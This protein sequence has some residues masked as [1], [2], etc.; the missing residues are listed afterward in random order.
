[1][2][3]C[4]L[5]SNTKSSSTQFATSPEA[6]QVIKDLLDALT[7]PSEEDSIASAVDTTALATDKVSPSARRHL[8]L[9]RSSSTNEMNVQYPDDQSPMESE[10]GKLPETDTVTVVSPKNLT[11]KGRRPLLTRWNICKLLAEFVR[12]YS[13]VAKLVTEHIYTP[14][15]TE[16]V[17]NECSA[18]SYMLDC[19]VCGS[20]GSGNPPTTEDGRG[21]V[22]LLIG[23]LASCSH[24]PDAQGILV[25][26]VK[27]ALSRA[28]L[29]PESNTKHEQLQSL[30]HLICTMM[31]TCPPHYSSPTS[32]FH[33]NNVGMNNMIRILVRKGVVTDLARIPHCL[34]LS[35]PNLAVTINVA[36]KALEMVAR[37]MNHLSVAPT[38]TVRKK[39]ASQETTIV[40][41]D[42]PNDGGDANATTASAGGSSAAANIEDGGN[43]P[44]GN[45][46][47]ADASA[48]T[49]ATNNVVDTTADNEDLEDLEDTDM[50]HHAVLQDS[51]TVQ[52]RGRS[53]LDALLRVFDNRN[54]GADDESG[55]EGGDDDEDSDV[56]RRNRSMATLAFVIS[57]D[58]QPMD[59]EEDDT[60]HDSRMVTRNDSQ[61]LNGDDDANQDSSSSSDTSDE[62]D[63]D[64]DDDDDNDDNEG[65]NDDNDEVVDDN[66]A[67]GEDAQQISLVGILCRLYLLTRYTWCDFHAV[68]TA[69]RPR[70]YLYSIN[71]S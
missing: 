68:K 10:S 57:G 33:K 66:D 17:T 55:G 49:H 34:D 1:M 3:F 16:H 61:F 69:S 37:V 7:V 32:L 67:D 53:D 28:C 19:L 48:A 5:G 24:A 70:K 21:Y 30:I 20:A 47:A 51:D 26:E 63:D 42:N 54:L 38:A 31:E 65:D 64:D 62:D 60:M 46:L 59:T 56:P 35:S 39:Q 50:R 71:R 12:C 9:S 2:I 4:Q 58:H 13:D 29:A 41:S 23:A 36:L 18:L 11:A 22:R 43:N 6:Q 40:G 27:S 15:T 52:D 25:T 14:E 45:S 44:D 8:N